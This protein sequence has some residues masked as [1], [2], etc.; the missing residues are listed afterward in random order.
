[1]LL[2]LRGQALAW[3]G[4]FILHSTWATAYGVSSAVSR[5]LANLPYVLWVAAFNNTQLLICCL[6]ETIFFHSV[7]RALGKEDEGELATLA[8]SH[9][10]AALH[11]KGLPVFLVGNIFTGTINMSIQTLDVSTI[12]AE[13][14]LILY[15]AV[16]TRVAL[17]LEK[18][19][20]KLR[21]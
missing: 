13:G 4:L 21:L 10:M 1:M 14:G 3:T 5:R 11:R 15:A 18:T 2:N 6:F 8:T 9:I 20:I 7:H 19:N 12:Q 16:L 17:A